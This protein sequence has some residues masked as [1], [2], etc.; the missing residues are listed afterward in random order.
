MTMLTPDFAS[1]P[2]TSASADLADPITELLRRH[3]RDLIA[4][5][6]EAEVTFGMDQLRRDGLDVVRNGYLPER[7]ITTAVGDVA[8]SVPRIHSKDGEPV[9]VASSM[10]PKYLRRSTSIDALA[11]F[12]YLKGVSENDVASVLEV[13]LGEGAL[14]LWGDEVGLRSNHAVGRS[15]SPGGRRPWSPAP[16]SASEPTSSRR[17]RT[18]ASS[19]SWSFPD[20]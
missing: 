4:V 3:V 6:L 7:D 8:V 19:T 5:A 14:I 15:W 12:A 18:E 1:R 16:G 13:M 2:G 10:I 11:A 9:T 17:C 20:A